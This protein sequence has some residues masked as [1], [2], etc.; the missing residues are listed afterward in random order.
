MPEFLT[1]CSEVSNLLNERPIGVKPSED[2][3][4]NLTPN[5][6][7][8]GRA[9]V[10]HPTLWDGNLMR[11]T[12]PLRYHLVQSVVKDFW[13]R[14][15]EFFLPILLVQR[16]WHTER[17]NLCPGDVVIMADSNMPR[18]DYRLAVV[19]EVF[20]GEDRKVRRVTIQYKSYRTGERAHE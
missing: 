12:F 2:S 10:P 16:K 4:I 5:G 18:E 13:K 15:A 14:W 20:P 7:L 6:L 8:L 19:K 9:T 11:Q 1:L 3:N 17:C